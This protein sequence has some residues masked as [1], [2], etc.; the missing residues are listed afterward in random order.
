MNASSPIYTHPSGHEALANALL[1]GLAAARRARPAH[2]VRVPAAPKPNC[3]DAVDAW[4]STHAGTLAVRGWLAVAL[5]GAP[6]RFVAHS[7]VRDT[8]NA[9]LDPTFLSSDPVLPFVPHP[10][11]VDGFFA[12]LCGRSA[13]HE[14]L[15]FNAPEDAA[16]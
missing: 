9:L 16:P 10:R 5:D 3:H 6:L 8:D 2:H 1:S 13:P 12:L 14:L 11:Q 4:V 7:L 15:V